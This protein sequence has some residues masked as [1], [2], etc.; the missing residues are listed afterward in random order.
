MFNP[1]PKKPAGG[2]IIAHASC[3]RYCLKILEWTMVSTDMVLIALLHA[4]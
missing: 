2:N 4:I 3:T 1:D